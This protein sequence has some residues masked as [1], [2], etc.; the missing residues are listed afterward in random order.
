MCRKND[1]KEERGPE[2]GSLR[3]PEEMNIETRIPT[4]TQTQTHIHTPTDTHAHRHTCT[5]IDTHTHR[6]T[7]THIQT[8]THLISSK[9]Y[10]LKLVLFVVFTIE[11]GNS[12]RIPLLFSDL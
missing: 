3:K 7:D 1:V 8:H 9:T 6:H 2:R 11:G 5:Q 12:G 10:F 4:D